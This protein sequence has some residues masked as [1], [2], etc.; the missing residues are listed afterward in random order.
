M[1]GIAI[2]K[3]GVDFS[4]KG[5]GKV[6]RKG[7]TSQ[8]IKLQSLIIKD[9]GKIEGDKTLVKF[10]AEYTPANTQ[11]TA[12]RWVSLNPDILCF[13]DSFSGVAEVFHGD[14]EDN[15][16]IVCISVVD[17]SIHANAQVTVGPWNTITI[18]V[19][20]LSI[21]GADSADWSDDT[22]QYTV[23]YTPSNTT[24]RTVSWSSSDASV[25]TVDANGLVT[26]K[27]GTE[28]KTVVITA[29]SKD[30]AALSASKTIT[31]KAAPQDTFPYFKVGE[32]LDG[33]EVDVVR[34]ISAYSP[35]NYYVIGKNA[36]RMMGV[37]RA[38]RTDVKHFFD[39]TNPDPTAPLTTSEI[40]NFNH[41]PITL[42]KE[43]IGKTLTLRR[44]S[45]F[46]NVKFAINTYH[47]DL[48]TYYTLGAAEVQDTK[49]QTKTELSIIITENDFA[50]QDHCFVKLIFGTVNDKAY[51]D[52]EWTAIKDKFHFTI[53]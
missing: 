23:V 21:S 11:Q 48:S 46:P 37:M 29:T 33:T 27:H 8:A 47:I 6:T 52:D 7:E 18:A 20:G 42:G 30:N 16:E 35:Q 53:S 32:L 34:G 28:D 43:Y 12:V 9:M 26:F 24:Q 13:T 15:V 10:E 39:T 19:T 44:D 22:L 36:R 14:Q 3:E 40:E 50:S 31:V 25:A 49:W 17:G 4:S 45:T 5:L 41:L 1:S 2:I 38:P 51:T